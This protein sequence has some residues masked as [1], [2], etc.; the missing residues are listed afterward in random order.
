LEGTRANDAGG[1][2]V[3]VGVSGTHEP[4]AVVLT[5]DL[6]KRDAELKIMLGC[7]EA[8]MQTILDFH[9]SN[10]MRA[11]LVHRTIIY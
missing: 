10:S 7:T 8:E 11:Y 9:N 5:V 4:S 2:D 3:W 6:L 1:I